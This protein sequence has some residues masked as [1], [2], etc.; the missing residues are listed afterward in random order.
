MNQRTQQ[1]SSSVQ[2]VNNRES[3]WWESCGT[4]MD[5]WMAGWM[6]DD[7]SP[8]TRLERDSTLFNFLHVRYWSSCIFNSTNLSQNYC[9]PIIFSLPNYTHFQCEHEL[10]ITSYTKP[11]EPG[12]RVR[13]QHDSGIDGKGSDS[14]WT[15]NWRTSWRFQD[16]SKTVRRNSTKNS[17]KKKLKK[18][19]NKSWTKI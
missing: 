2:M 4:W 15:L 12:V 6:H 13:P 9:I 17:N 19:K 8:G 7:Q 14:G 11:R 18:N 16:T 10:S 3:S 1:R 5:G